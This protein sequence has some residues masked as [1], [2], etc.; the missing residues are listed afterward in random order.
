MT[1]AD[2]EERQR[3]LDVASSKFLESGISK[4][5]LDEISTELGMSKKTVYKFF[6]SKDM[7]LHAIVKM[8]LSH[9]EREVTSIVNSDE[10]SERKLMRVLTQAGKYI[11]HISRQF[12]HDVQRFAPSL[13]NEIDKFRREHILSHVKRIFDQAKNE[14]VFKSD[15]NIDLFYLVFISTVQGIM[16]PKMLSEHSFSAEE[17][18]RGIVRIL[19]EGALTDE[20]KQRTHYFEIKNNS[21]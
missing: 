19:L 1:M 4:V 10:P 6:P 13:W 8:L 3:I 21:I 14:N 2:Q 20:A 9:A 7:L 17:A 5:T 15:L 11:R 18:F 16:N 12:Q